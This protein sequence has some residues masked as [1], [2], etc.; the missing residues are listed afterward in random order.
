MHAAVKRAEF[1]R[2]VSAAKRHTFRCADL[3]VEIGE[4][5]VGRSPPDRQLH[6]TRAPPSQI[7]ET[8]EA[9][10]AADHTEPPNPPGRARMRRWGDRQRTPAIRRQ[11]QQL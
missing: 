5:R 6:K 7:A 10:S 4:F 2:P 1:C 8:I 3:A 9:L 11:R